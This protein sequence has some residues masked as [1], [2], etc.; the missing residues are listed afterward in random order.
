MLQLLKSFIH[1]AADMLDRGQEAHHLLGR[2]SGRVEDGCS[3]MSLI[4]A[5]AVWVQKQGPSFANIYHQ[6]PQ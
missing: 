2:A 6:L 4:V 3:F 5:E 1:S